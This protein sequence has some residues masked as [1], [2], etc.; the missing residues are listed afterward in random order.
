MQTEAIDK[1]FLE[2]AQFTTAK[3]PRELALEIRLRAA[4]AGRPAG[5]PDETLALLKVAVRHVLQAISDDPAKYWLLGEGTGSWE[6]LTRAAAAA[7][8]E[9]LDKVQQTFRPPERARRAYLEQKRRDEL[10][11]QYC[12]ENGISANRDSA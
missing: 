4:S 11:L 9:P 12:R 6:K 1:L 8:G 10:L 5:P 2:L 3:T 7:F